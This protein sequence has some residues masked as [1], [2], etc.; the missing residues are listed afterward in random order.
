MSFLTIMPFINFILIILLLINNIMV[1]KSIRER[2]LLFSDEVDEL[3]LPDNI[4]NID[5]II[6]RNSKNKYDVT[7]EVIKDIQS[8]LDTII[9]IMKFEKGKEI[10]IDE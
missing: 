9:Q 10:N 1:H 5:A 3:K 4:K 8:K 2:L 6:L 7:S